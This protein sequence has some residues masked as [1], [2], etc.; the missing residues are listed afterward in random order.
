MEKIKLV[1]TLEHQLKYQF[2]KVL[3]NLHFHQYKKHN[4][5]NKL[6]LQWLKVSIESSPPDQ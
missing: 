6:I 3:N 5:V 1:L 2:K 4:H